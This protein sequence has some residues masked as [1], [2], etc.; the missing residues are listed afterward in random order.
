[1]T[2][3]SN[4]D[5][6][7]AGLVMAM[8]DHYLEQA[9]V[10]GRINPPLYPVRASIY[11]K[12]R[13]DDL[14][15]TSEPQ[16]LMTREEGVPI[17]AIGSL[18]N[19]PTT[20]LIWLPRSGIH[21]IG[22]LEGRAI[23]TAGLSY[24]AAFVKAILAHAGLPPRSAKILRAGYNEVTLLAKGKASAILADPTVAVPELESRGLSPRVLPVGK[25]GIPP[26]EQLVVIARKDRLGENS[27]PIRAFMSALAQGTAAAK[28]DPQAVEEALPEYSDRSPAV[29]AAGL[30]RIL[31]LLS[32]SN[33]MNPV[34]W[35]RFAAWMRSE[36][37]LSGHPSAA[38]AL[39]DAYLPGGASDTP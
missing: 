4:F 1:M 21:G 27:Q 10:E 26:Y 8:H 12:I 9:G 30:Q 25:L 24:E 28:K 36:G 7:H 5:A 6:E 13:V 17:V 38:S 37:L 2:L 18:L 3:D 19:Q 31:P 35:Q 16:V 22:D 15:L 23:A 14:G 33:R 34:R 29:A 32:G 39:T 20:A 11:V